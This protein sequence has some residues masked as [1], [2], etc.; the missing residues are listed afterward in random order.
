M[1]YKDVDFSV[2]DVDKKSRIVQG[3]F[4]IF[5]NIDA[6]LDIVEKGA[7][8]KSISENGPNSK[9]PRIKHLLQ[10]NTLKPVGLLLDLK[11]D[12]Q[13]LFF[14]SRISKSTDGND[15]LTLYDEGILTEHSI[16]FNILDSRQ[17]TV[18]QTEV[19]RLTEL[20]LWE[21]STVTWGANELAQVKNW[22]QGTY[23]KWE[24]KIDAWS[25]VLRK[26]NLSDEACE[27][28]EIELKQVQGL[29]ETLTKPEE[30]TSKAVDVSDLYDYVKSEI[31]QQ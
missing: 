19:N 1:L 3:Y 11:E 18:G 22:N 21:G 26:G 4:S 13:G 10:H 2:K 14:E 31:S 24:E 29:L 8:R 27:R 30:S 17:D 15:T 20:K 25:K 9:R 6:D 7:F 16:G 23:K 12:E 28:L 5:G